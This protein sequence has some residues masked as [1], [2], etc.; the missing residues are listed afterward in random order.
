VFE[1][2]GGVEGR[3]RLLLSSGMSV[4]LWLFMVSVAA[5]GIVLAMC[6]WA[7]VSWKSPAM[8]ERLPL[9]IAGLVALGF[10]FVMVADAS[11]RGVFDRDFVLEVAIGMAFWWF[12]APRVLIRSLRRPL[13]PGGAR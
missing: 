5:P 7:V 10:V 9:R 12:I 3:Q 13:V 6:L 1:A 2:H 11:L 8:E 4:F